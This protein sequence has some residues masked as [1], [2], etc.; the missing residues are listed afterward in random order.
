MKKLNEV[1]KGI[2]NTLFGIA[3]YACI[4]LISAL[5][6]VVFMIFVGRYFFN[7]S[8]M[9]AEPLSLLCLTWMSMLGSA[10]VVRGDDHIKVTVFDEKMGKKGLLATDILSTACI[11]IFALFLIVYGWKLTLRGMKNNLAGLNIP[12]GI[13]YVAMPV[14]GVLYIFGLVEM[15]RK[16]LV[17]E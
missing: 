2:D 16:R 1:W 4:V 9:W 12:Y 14:T 15:W 6:L 5:I 11:A 13:M 10:L 3:R 8:P 17:K 7:K